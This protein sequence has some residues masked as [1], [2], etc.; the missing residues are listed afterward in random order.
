MK[1]GKLPLAGNPI[2]TTSP[3]NHVTTTSYNTAGEKTAV[4]DPTNRFTKY[5][6][7]LAGRVVS[8]VSG[9]NT[10]TAAYASPVATTTYDLA[11]RPTSSSDCTTTGTGTCA[12]TLR[13]R[14]T[15]YDGAGRTTQ[16]TSAQ[17]RPT[18]YSYDTAG[19]LTSVTQRR[20]TTDA[21]TAVTVGLGYDRNGNKTR[22]VDGNSN[23]TTYTYTP[24]NL[25]ESTIEA[26]T[27]THPNATDQIGRAHV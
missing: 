15:V 2:T 14:S 1:R 3:L 21:L 5:T 25:P 20:V 26:S 16:T 27:V 13:S 22:M 23:A 12:T 10:P 6:L 9:Q 24:W 7:D 8:T 4:T 11:G 19:Q 17:G 18:F